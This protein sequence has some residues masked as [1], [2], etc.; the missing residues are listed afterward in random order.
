MLCS[1]KNCKTPGKFNGK[2]AKHFGVVKCF[3]C[4]TIA[5]SGGLCEIHRNTIKSNELHSNIKMLANI[6]VKVESI[7]DV[8]KDEVSIADNKIDNLI[9]TIKVKLERM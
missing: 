8:P 4:D 6:I 2:C 1:I 7:P 9:N 3:K 5:Q